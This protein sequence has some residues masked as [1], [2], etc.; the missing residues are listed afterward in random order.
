[1]NY[2]FD[3][4]ESVLFK[5]APKQK[6]LKSIAN[7]ILAKFSKRKGDFLSMAGCLTLINSVISGAL[8]HSS[9]I[10]KW[11]GS[12]LKEIEAAMRNFLGTG[13]IFDKKL[14]SVA[15]AKTYVPK[16]EGGL[17]IRSLQAINS[18]FITKMAWRMMTQNS[19]VANFFRGKYLRQFDE[20]RQGPFTSSI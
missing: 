12:L 16:I 2:H 4:W 6:H 11:L 19:I 10:Y 7:S 15:W 14:I 9:M 1:M 18:G 8:N 3:T 13:N 5:G 17:G 20:P